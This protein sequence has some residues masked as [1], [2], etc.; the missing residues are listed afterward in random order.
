MIAKRVK[1]YAK[2][3]LSLNING[4]KDGYHLLDSVFCSIDIYDTILAKPR[5][6]SLI[7]VYMHGLGSESI[8]PE[9][10]NAVKAG[11][12]FVKT[13]K[14]NGADIE[15]YKDIPIGAGLGGS[16]AD[17]AGVI[18]AMA[19]IYKIT[20]KS[21]LKALALSL[22]SD[23]GYMLGGSFARVT[24]KGEKIFPLPVKERYH[25]L[26]IIPDSQVSSGECYKKYDEYP[27]EIARH[28]SEICATGLVTGNFS[29]VAS[30]VYNALSKPS[31]ALDKNVERALF[32]A[33]EFSPSAYAVTG[34]GSAVFALF[35]TEELCRWAKSCYK[36]KFKTRVVHT[37]VP[38][39]K[40]KIQNPYYLTEEER[41]QLKN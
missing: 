35:E 9:K 33:A 30:G 3:N 34:S 23:A 40:K 7:N 10:N 4:V 26:L 8:P 6:D 12:A 41:Q 24:S 31:S 36:G 28:D 29:L 38:I 37:I 11:E 14:T 21:A 16:S 15:I 13:F 5:K 17:V 22:S 18:N 20:D 32:E 39:E 1:S 25:M 27:D 2:I 19:K